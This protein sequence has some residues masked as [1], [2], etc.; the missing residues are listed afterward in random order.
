MP[1]R[2]VCFHESE[3]RRMF[4]AE[5][6]N[7]KALQ[8]ANRLR[9]LELIRKNPGIVRGAIIEET[10]L[11][12][13]SVSNIVSYLISCGL[14]REAG[15]ESAERAGRK[16]IRLCFDGSAFQLVT[17]CHEDEHLCLYLS[18]LSGHVYSKMEYLVS[19]LDADTF[20]SLLLDAVRSML[21]LPQARRVL[22]VGV[23]MSALVLDG[24]RR[25]ISSALGCDH[26][27]LPGLLADTGL[28]VH[29]SNS[30]FTKAMWLCRSNP[31]WNRGLTLF[32]D[33]SRGMGAALIRSGSQMPEIIGE[34]GHTTVCMDGDACNCGNRGCLERMCAPERMIRLYNESTGASVSDL[35]AFARRFEL[36][37]PAAI[38]ALE[39][40]AQYL[41]IGLANLVNLFNPDSIVLNAMDFAAC[42]AVLDRAREAMQRR[43]IAGLGSRA[44]YHLTSFNPED[45]PLATACELC[46]ALFSEQNK[47]DMFDLVEQL[48]FKER[49][50]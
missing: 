8:R 39:N 35:S 34:I 43:A 26:L 18:D 38:D 33:I 10:G 14:V 28:P 22:G 29:V 49:T 42:P 20:V 7:S 9:I 1:D 30:S 32:V 27:D 3:V 21:R 24:G 5:V 46:D 23:S 37:D 2:H 31:G 17:A 19:G 45:W 25:V 36:G 6:Q 13:A 15:A 44:Q 48:I 41:G 4:K 50:V 12:P 40:C 11:S 16:R 47:S